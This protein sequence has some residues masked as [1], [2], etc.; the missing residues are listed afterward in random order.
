MLP[1]NQLRQLLR[2]GAQA[3]IV[4]QI[5]SQFVTLIVLSVLYRLLG[6]DPYGLLG[7]VL[8]LFFLLRIVIPGGL[9]VAAIQQREVNPDQ[10]SVLFWVNQFLGVLMA[11]VAVAAAPLLAWFYALAAACHAL[12]FHAVAATPQLAWSYYDPKICAVTLALAGTSILLALVTQHQALLQRHMRLGTLAA[13][14]LSAQILGG[15]TGITVAVAQ[16]GVWA[17]VAQ[18][19]AEFLTLAILCWWSVPWRPQW[20]LWHTGVRRM[21]H[22]GGYFTFSQLMFFFTTNADK[23]LVGS[24]LGKVAL[25][26]YSQA[27]NVMMKPVLALLV[28]LCGIMLPSL[29]RA[30][31]NGPQYRNL[32]LGYFRA[33]GLAMFPCTIGLAIVGNEAMQVLGGDRWIG[34]GRLLTVLGLAA[35]AQAFFTSFGG[36]FA[37]VGRADRLFRASIVI[38]LV[39]T[40]SFG[41]GYSVG[42]QYG[43]P[44]QGVTASFT[45]ALVFLVF[46]GYLLL[47]LNTVGI[48]LR[49][50]LSQMVRPAL[51]AVGMGLAVLAVKYALN[52]VY[53]ALV[54][55]MSGWQQRL[56]CPLFWRE[57][58]NRDVV[59]LTC[60]VTVGIVVYSLLARKD[61]RWLVR[62]RHEPV[63]ATSYLGQTVPE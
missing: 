62:L 46:P 13:I 9:D 6:P 30:A 21:L 55:V 32:L 1:P 56:H 15:I 14:R 38:A 63:A 20:K 59:L 44:L 4:A 28:P 10:I 61:I 23:I 11:A 3:V 34:A 57:I 22:T 39:M 45:L 18:Q 37:S 41:V 19:Y 29:S 54:A 8:P 51:A 25:G 50:W 7:M 40:A 5:C 53:P 27:F 52:A 36:I 42:L 33:I 31:S 47:C 24:L 17:L 2:R 49:D 12:G 60:E 58:L 48:S 43:K 35:F 16:Q 26:L